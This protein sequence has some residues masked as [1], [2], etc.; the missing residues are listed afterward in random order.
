MEICSIWRNSGGLVLTKYYCRVHNVSASNSITI[1][2]MQELGRQ[3]SYLN[4][5]PIGSGTI[6]VKLDA[7]AEIELNKDQ[8]ND[9]LEIK[10]SEQLFKVGYVEITTSSSTAISVWVFAS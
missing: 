10:F 1:N 5:K 8:A 9:S 2:F 7:G 4:V 3:A 6:K